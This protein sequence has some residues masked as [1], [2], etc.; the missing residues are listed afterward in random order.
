MIYA[1]Y[2]PLVVSLLAAG[3]APII[4]AR[5]PARIA[6]WTL[7]AFAV[8]AAVCGTVSLALLAASHSGSGGSPNP[9]PV[10]VAVAAMVLLPLS[11]LSGTVML[12][13]RR[14]ALQSVRRAYLG[15]DAGVASE[16]D[17]PVVEVDTAR[18]LA[19]SLP[20]DRR[21]PGRVV[22][23]RGMVEG[24][25]AAER[26]VLRAHEWSHLRRE[27]HR[28]VT[29]VRLAAAVNPLLRPVATAATFAVERWA[30]EDAAAVSQ[31]RR[32]TAS[33]VGKAALLASAYRT[34]GHDEEVDTLG[35]DGAVRVAGVLRVSGA[36]GVSGAITG[37]RRP[38][39]VPRRVAAL[40][41]PPLPSRPWWTAACV[42]VML[43]VVA[44]AAEGAYDLGGL[45][46][47]WTVG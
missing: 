36:L 24:L 4:A 37:L 10:V 20:G 21:R 3:C 23:S 44:A 27:H 32:L 5:F 40:L 30:D 16:G 17:D 18:P 28:L 33:A 34:G 22:V 1:V 19:F 12:V 6:T 14:R 8:V 15:S 25:D 43:A 31:D 38:G 45:L 11:L 46:G 35:V 13:R 2:L 39:V 26:V 7:T 42:L 29:A 41:A 47:F 9:V